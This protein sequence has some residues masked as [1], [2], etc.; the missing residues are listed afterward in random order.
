MY[1]WIDGNERN[2]LSE[3]CIVW[4][5]QDLGAEGRISGELQPR[6]MACACRQG[7][8][9]HQGLTGIWNHELL[10]T[11]EGSTQ[12]SAVLWDGQC[13][14]A[15]VPGGPAAMHARMSRGAC[16]GLHGTAAL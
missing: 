5:L 15:V 14:R 3:R 6:A 10:W 9:T 12:V 2:K 7:H 16:I 11:E 1:S 4:C 13:R 8:H